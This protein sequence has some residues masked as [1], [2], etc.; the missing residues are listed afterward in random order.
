MLRNLLYM[1][2]FPER[3]TGKSWSKPLPVLTAQQISTTSTIKK[4]DR[5]TKEKLK[6]PLG[7]TG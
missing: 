5:E 1:I 4:D 6:G 3:Q 2:L 7:G